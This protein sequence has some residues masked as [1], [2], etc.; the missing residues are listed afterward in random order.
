[1]TESW[2]KIDRWVSGLL[3]AAT[4]LCFG[5]F[6]AVRPLADWDEGLYANIA[7]EIARSGNWLHLA[8]QGASWFDKEPFGFW[9]MA[10]AV[11]L[12]GWNIW[13]LRLPSLLATVATAPIFYWLLRTRLSRVTAVTI[14]V[15][16]WSGPVLWYRHMLGTADLEALTLLFSVAI[17]AA[18]IRW[19]KRVWPA[20][21]LWGVFLLT[22][23][24]WA[25]PFLGFL[26]VG[27]VIHFWQNKNTRRLVNFVG[28]VVL[29]CVPWLGWHGLQYHYNPAE[30]VRVYWQEQF[31]E[32]ITGQVDGHG[33]GPL[34]YVDFFKN[35]LGVGYAM[36]LFLGALWLVLS[37][38]YPTQW[39]WPVWLLVT[40]VPPHLLGTKLSWYVVPAIP[41]IF[42]ALGWLVEQIWDNGYLSGKM[43]VFLASIM[44]LSGL[45]RTNVVYEYFLY[46]DRQ[47][48]KIVHTVEA[49]VG[50][51]SPV[52]V[53]GVRSWT[54]GRVLPVMYWHT[55]LVRQWELFSVDASVVAHYQAQPQAYPWWWVTTSTLA[56]LKTTPFAGCVVATTTDYVF[57]TTVTSSPACHGSL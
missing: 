43:L 12:F 45:A 1:M 5:L 34:F 17:P 23:G 3:A 24:V 53:Y 50:S 16:L 31:V 6:A 8:L 19:S 56:T 51:R 9:L 18:Y 21:A 41:A 37:T 35:Q 33:G 27:E 44:L 14:S 2:A 36:L 22:R 54:F 38:K 10:S 25:L 46:T 32:R 28:A 20:V 47:V 55:H 4:G 42:A 49:V 11:K 52:V 26:V 15:L 39:E 48:E 40:A 30:Y 7:G 29:A 57:L 13:A